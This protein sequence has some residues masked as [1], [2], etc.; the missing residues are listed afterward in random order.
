[1][2]GVAGPTYRERVQ[3][4]PATDLVLAAGVAAAGVAETIVPFSSRQGDGSVV[5]TVLGA[6]VAGGLLAFRRTVPLVPPVGLLVLFPLLQLQGPVYLL[7]YGQLL[8]LVLAMYSVARHG[9]G[10]G[11]YAGIAA[12]A[13]LLLLGELTVPL[14]QDPGERVFHWLVVGLAGLVGWGLARYEARSRAA[15]RRAVEAEVAAAHQ[16]MEAVVA[17]RTRIAQ[18]L[19][20]IVAHAVSVMVVQAGAAEQAVRDDPEFARAALATIRKTGSGA[21]GEM[22]RVVAVLR[23]VD[24]H[25]REQL[26]PLPGVDGLAGLVEATRAG[27]LDAT[28]AVRGHE[29]P[30]PAGLEL[31][32]YR[33]VQEAL[34]NVRRHARASTAEVTVDFAPSSLLITVQDDG[35]GTA[36]PNAGGH[37]LVGMRERA[38]LYGGTVEAAAAPGGGFAVRAVLPADVT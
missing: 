25:G 16:A 36:E 6:V 23:D 37:G 34:T 12:V 31:A 19:H 22:R 5:V 4:P 32:A 10:R 24:D 14:L 20:D 3:R 7:F 38:A 35:V 1:M 27:G 15:T 11:R 28:L 17:E 9:H 21:L 13:L 33:I 18:E 29:R 30:L 26:T 8:P 2:S